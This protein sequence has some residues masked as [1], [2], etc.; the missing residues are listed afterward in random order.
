MGV[1]H[2]RGGTTT[3]TRIVY[4]GRTGDAEVGAENARLPAVPGADVDAV[5]PRDRGFAQYSRAAGDGDNCD[6]IRSSDRCETPTVRNC[7]VNNRGMNRMHAN[8]IAGV[9]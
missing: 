6:A 8:L 4:P 9:S 3:S 2:G 1:P 7:W 5:H